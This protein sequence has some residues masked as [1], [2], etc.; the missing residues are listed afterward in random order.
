ML[1]VS[2]CFRVVEAG[3]HVHD[4]LVVLAEDGLERRDP[5]ADAQCRD[6]DGGVARRRRAEVRDRH[7]QRIVQW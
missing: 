5:L 2:G 4:W 7:R 6:V 1:K 3:D